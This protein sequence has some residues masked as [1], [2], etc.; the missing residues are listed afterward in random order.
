MNS[1]I[2]SL[3]PKAPSLVK[4][5]EFRPIAFYN[6]L[7][8][9]ITKTL[10]N[11]L[12]QTLPLFISKNQCAFVE[13]RLMVENVLLAQEVVKHYHKPQLSPRCALKIDLM[14]AFDSISRDFIFQVLISLGF[15]TH[16]V[17][18]LK[19]CITTP[20]FSIAFN[21]NLCGYFPGKKG[22]R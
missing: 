7:Y 9:L 17:N 22:V 5:T 10:A 13:G 21:C 3:V 19:I 20:M 16:F 14:K 2:I 12:K 4:M 18:L 11:K 15:P 8:K 6:L 1:I